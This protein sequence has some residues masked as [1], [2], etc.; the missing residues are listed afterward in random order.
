MIGNGSATALRRCTNPPAGSLPVRRAWTGKPDIGEASGRNAVRTSA[1]SRFIAESAP[2][3]TVLAAAFPGSAAGP[4]RRC[5]RS[6]SPEAETPAAR[7]RTPPTAGKPAGSPAGPG[8]AAP[9][10]ARCTVPSPLA[11]APGGVGTLARRADDGLAVGAAPALRAVA[12]PGDGAAPALRA[13][14][15]P[16]DGAAPVPRAIVRPGGGKADPLREDPAGG[17]EDAGDAAPF[18]ARICV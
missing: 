11:A 6:A 8:P 7:A 17:S 16:G 13:T 15:R 18:F 4:N 2:G 1:G 14:V 5:L 9:R 3:T 12:G 10:V